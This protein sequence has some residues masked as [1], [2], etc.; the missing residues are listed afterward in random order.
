[1]PDDKNFDNEKLFRSNLIPKKFIAESLAVN[2]S[3][4]TVSPK[5]RKTAISLATKDGY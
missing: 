4:I 2:S 3:A 1:M 5:E